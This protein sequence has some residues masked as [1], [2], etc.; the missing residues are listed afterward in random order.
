[1]QCRKYSFVATT[2]LTLALTS[3]AWAQ[4]ANLPSAADPGRFDKKFEAPQAPQ[5]PEKTAPMAPNVPTYAVPKEADIR[6]PVRDIIVEGGS[7]YPTS[8]WDTWIA[9]YRNREMSL[10]E[11][12][13]VAEK[14]TKHYQRDGYFLSRAI[15]PPQEVEN[16]KVT[17]RVVEGFVG[18]VSMEGDKPLVGLARDMAAELTQI[19]P[20]N[21]SQLERTL[22]LLN[23]LPGIHV[24]GV[25]R[26][27]E[28][29]EMDQVGAVSLVLMTEKEPA[30]QVVT[31][32]NYGSRYLGPHQIGYRFDRGDTLLDYDRITFGTFL[33]TPFDE[34]N[35]AFAG[36]KIPLD[37]DGTTL[38][39]N[40]NASKSEPGYTLAVNRVEGEALGM[41]LEIEH[42]LIRSRGRNWYVSA[43]F[44]S[45]HTRNDILGTRFFRDEVRALR[46]S[47]SYDF[48]D[49]WAGA[50]VLRGTL[51]QGLNILGATETGA[52]DLSRAEAR[53]NFTKFEGSIARLQQL[54]G[55]W[56]AFAA[57]SGQYTNVPLFSSE[58][59]GYGGQVFGRAYDASEITGD[60]GVAATAEL[61]YSDLGWFESWPLQPYAFYDV[62][63]TYN[64][65]TNAGTNKD[66]S[67]ASAG[68]GM[69]FSYNEIVYG[70]F[71]VAQPLTRDV[72][73]PVYG[74]DGDDPRVFFS[75]SYQW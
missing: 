9:P 62:G 67:G 31:F 68:I 59:F 20:L 73:A 34:L 48:L 5:S 29:A 19:R 52:A 23:D 30:K 42:P 1:M 33:S 36:Y 17:L 7:I 74:Q 22:M 13:G 6:F 47:S 61:R 35:Y 75:L 3:A 60:R 49:D 14:I 21:A 53:S 64:L 65:D 56:Q 41:G 43:E 45:Q 54:G 38:A 18:R 16:G 40:I 27:A 72:E 28:D 66:R 15:V 58:E 8:T 24:R 69:R 46:L 50:N 37:T 11:L 4:T 44:N 26:G 63:R 55:A 51:S 39:F 57:V 12:Y 32:D 25:L 70:A 71:T 10:A 2:A